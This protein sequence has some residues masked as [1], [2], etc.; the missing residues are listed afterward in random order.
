LPINQTRARKGRGAR[1]GEAVHPEVF[2]FNI[3][4]LLALTP[5]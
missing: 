4:G 1:S 5:Q 2:Y 3:N